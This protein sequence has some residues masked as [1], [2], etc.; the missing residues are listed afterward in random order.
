MP[1]YKSQHR[2]RDYESSC[3]SDKTETKNIGLKV[4]TETKNIGLKVETET[5]TDTEYK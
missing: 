5:K 4:E 2:N 1:K 3:L